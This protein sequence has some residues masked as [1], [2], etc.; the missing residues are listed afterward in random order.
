MSKVQVTQ[1]SVI[2]GGGLSGKYKGG[3]KF[4]LLALPKA[5]FNLND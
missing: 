5:G 4:S 3:T 1:W 2:E